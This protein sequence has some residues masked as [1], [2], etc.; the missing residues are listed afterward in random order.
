MDGNVAGMSLQER[1]A[2]I[3]LI[4]IC[5]FDQSLSA[6]PQ[7]LANTVG[8]P[9]RAFAKLWPTLKV[10]FDEVDGRLVHPRLEK[11][12][13]KQS[14]YRRRQSDRGKASAASRSTGGQPEGNHGSTTV[15]PGPQPEGNRK[16]TETPTGGQ[17]EGNSP[18]SDLRSPYSVPSEPQYARK[19]NSGS[20]WPIYKGNRLVVFDWMLT[21]MQQTLGQYAD[22]VEWDVWLDAADQ[23]ALQEPIVAADWWPW[24]Q[25]ELL[26]HARS[27]GWAV[28]V[29]TPGKPTLAARMATIVANARAEAQ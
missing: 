9:Y 3:T 25:A 24:L 15:Q 10:C 7:R 8:L 26:I 21:K 2:Y 20:R 18:I 17:P 6:D 13:E 12:R 5:W 19:P 16:A 23:R 22:E 4:C 27:Q 1:G 29:Q 14:E 11:E 28:A